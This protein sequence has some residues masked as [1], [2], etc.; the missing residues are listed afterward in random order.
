M[1]SVQDQWLLGTV[2]L[3]LLLTVITR[4]AVWTRR[5]SSLLTGTFRKDLYHGCDRAQPTQGKQRCT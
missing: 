4:F 5:E 1:I 3:F 2:S